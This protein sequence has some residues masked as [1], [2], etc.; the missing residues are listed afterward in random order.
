MF[1][2]LYFQTNEINSYKLT[3]TIYENDQVLPDVIEI[4][5]PFSLFSFLFFFQIKYLL[6]LFNSIR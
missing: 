4:S 5:V 3:R 6:V 2:L 1:I